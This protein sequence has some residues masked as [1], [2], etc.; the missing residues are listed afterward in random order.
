MKVQ[1]E[2]LLPPRWGKG[3]DGGVRAAVC[4]VWRGRRSRLKRSSLK[5]RA[6]TPIP[7]PF[8]IEGEGR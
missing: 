4:V 2:A 6:L 1:N 3:R 5:R 8:P 7:D